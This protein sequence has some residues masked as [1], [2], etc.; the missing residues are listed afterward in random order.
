MI[1]AA[2]ISTGGKF[3]TGKSHQEALE[4]MPPEVVTG[5]L[6]KQFA[7]GECQGFLTGTGAFYNRED[8]YAHAVS[9]GQIKDTHGSK[10]LQSTML[11]EGGAL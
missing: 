6:I 9:C 8:A 10:R 4:A 3:Y 1:T 7:D 11:P 5:E 2:A